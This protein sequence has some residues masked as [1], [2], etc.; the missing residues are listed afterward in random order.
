MGCGGNQTIANHAADAH[1]TA[2]VVFVPQLVFRSPFVRSIVIGVKVH[3]DSFSGQ[4]RSRHEH[5]GEQ[6]INLADVHA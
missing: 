3:A 4:H 6:V 5:R 1:F 2:L